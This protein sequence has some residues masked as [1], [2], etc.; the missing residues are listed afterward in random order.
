M[1]GNL[2]DRL[3]KLS[4]KNN[5]SPLAKYF[6][7]PEYV[8]DKDARKIQILF[9]KLLMIIS[10]ADET[11][12][13]TE[14]NL[15][16]DFA[17]EQC[18][19][20][21]E[22]REINVFSSVKPSKEEIDQILD[23]II[24]EIHSVSGRKEFLNAIKEIIDA[25]EILKDEEKVILELV[26]RKIK[27][28]DIPVLGNLIGNIN[29]KLKVIRDNITF[30]DK[31]KEYARNPVLPVLKRMIGENS[32]PYMEITAAK[33]GLAILMIHSDMEFHENE[34]KAFE[35]LVKKEC[36]L[37]EEK[38]IE[39]ASELLNISENYFEISY[40]ARIINDSVGEEEKINILSFLFKIARAD[41]VYNSYEDR[42]LKLISNYLLIPHNDFLALKLKKYD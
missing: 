38:A 27:R 12:D 31:S 39:V 10:Y 17:F 22:W 21:G 14:I 15:I 8:Q 20:E 16:K 19:T 37:K 18:L 23:N 40:L 2:N 30:E 13:D 33:L 7:N 24:N 35:D 29:R 32:L 11:A 6:Q 9:Y 41:K 28:S 25:D 26:E 34:K 42:Y 5:K 3:I 1:L 36:N 4:D